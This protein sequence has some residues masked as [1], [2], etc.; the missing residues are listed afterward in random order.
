[1]KNKL[2]F[3][4]A[5]LVLSV[6]GL[7]SCTKD[8]AKANTNVGLVGTWELK[9]FKMQYY[10]NDTLNEDLTLEGTE[11]INE[12]GRITWEFKDGNEIVER[13]YDGDSMYL[14]NYSYVQTG[15]SLA[16]VNKSDTSETLL[17]TNYKNTGSEFTGDLFEEEN[18]DGIIAK[19]Y[20][21]LTFRKL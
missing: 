15:N 6:F 10:V 20:R 13:V 4:A 19:T 11:L 2:T 7:I 12:L 5:L 17:L 21:Y 18:I 16:L 1:M 14:G 3:L 8:D 9:K